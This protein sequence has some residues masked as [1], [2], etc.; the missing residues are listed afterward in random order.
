LECIEGRKGRRI[1]PAKYI[2]IFEASEQWPEV[3][4]W[5]DYEWKIVRKVPVADLEHSTLDEYEAEAEADPDEEKQENVDRVLEVMSLLR[6]GEDLWPV[7]LG[8]DCMTL[9]GYHRLSAAE[10]LGI[11]EIAVLYPVKRRT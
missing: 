6:A 3:A 11:M 2:H 9:D 5:R 1:D 8:L 7:V 10:E 4:R